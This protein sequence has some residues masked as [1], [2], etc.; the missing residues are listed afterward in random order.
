MAAT[1]HVGLYRTCTSFAGDPSDP[2]TGGSLCLFLRNLSDKCIFTNELDERREMEKMNAEPIFKFCISIFSLL[3]LSVAMSGCQGIYE[4]MRL[5]TIERCYAL[6]YPEQQ[7][8]L[9]ENEL[10]YEQYQQ[11]KERDLQSDI[12]VM[13]P[14]VDSSPPENE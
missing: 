12:T 6:P 8:C 10:N 2:K 5:Q 1:A 7:E 4:G 13:P 11:E 14:L 3:F 9:R